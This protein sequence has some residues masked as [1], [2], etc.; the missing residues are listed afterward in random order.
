VVGGLSALMLENEEPWVK[1]VG[2]ISSWNEVAPLLRL[3]C[4]RQNR[5]FKGRSIMNFL[6]SISYT[7]IPH[8]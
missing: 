6:L 1:L 7:I 5:N 8:V 4:E 2:P 3:E